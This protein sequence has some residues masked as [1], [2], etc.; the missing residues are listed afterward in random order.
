MRRKRRNHSP[1]F[2]AKVAFSALKGEKTLAQLA[3]E[4]DV[5]VNQ[6]Q[7][8]RN[9]LK[10]NMASLFDTGI[11]HRKDQEAERMTLTNQGNIR[12]TLKTII[13]KNAVKRRHPNHIQSQRHPRIFN[14]IS[15]NLA[16]THGC[17]DHPTIARGLSCKIST[18]T[19]V[20]SCSKANHCIPVEPTRPSFLV[21]RF[22]PPA[23]PDRSL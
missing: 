18:N 2:K 7:T 4:Y 5:H 17:D 20:F 13:W 15:Y 19:E 23:S 16:S 14:S 1:N 6:I 12:Y 10:Q 9:Q 22:T 8:W 3:S 11:A 21:W